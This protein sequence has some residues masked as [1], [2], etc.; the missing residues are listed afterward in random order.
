MEEGETPLR[1]PR[2][3]QGD[4]RRRRLGEPAAPRVT[5]SLLNF[6]QHTG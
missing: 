1:K 6:S 5:R 2:A 4:A 3:G